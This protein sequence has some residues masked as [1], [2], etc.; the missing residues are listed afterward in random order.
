VDSYDRDLDRAKQD[1]LS[2]GGLV[3]IAYWIVRG[4]SAFIG[5]LARRWRRET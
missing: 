3:S 4:V 1:R 2:S 5:L